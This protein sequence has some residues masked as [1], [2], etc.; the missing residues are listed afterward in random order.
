LKLKLSIKKKKDSVEEQP[1][2]KKKDRTD[3]QLDKKG[4][5]NE[6]PAEVKVEKDPSDELKYMVIEPTLT[7]SE[8]KLLH[9]LNDLL[10]E[11]MNTDVTEFESHEKTKEYLMKQIDMI[12]KKYHAKANEA[13]ISKIKYYLVRNYIGYGKIDLMMRDPNVEDISCNGPGLPIFVWHRKYESIPANILFSNPEELDGFVVK[14]AD[15]ADKAVSIAQPVVDAHLPDGSR[16]HATYEKEVTSRG[17]SFTIRKFHET[18][19]TIINL[20]ASNT[21]SARLA[22]WFWYMIENQA[23]IIAIGGTASGKTTT[24]N[25][26]A[27]FIKPNSKIVSIEDTAE[28]KLLHENWL[29]SVVRKGFGISDEKADISLFDLLKNALR[30]RPDYII[31]GEVRGVEAYTLFQA[32]A[33]GHGGIATFHAESVES[34]VR[35][36][37]NEPLNVPRQLVTNVD[38]IV[39]QG[40]VRYNDKMVRRILAV[41][42]ILLDPAT[43]EIK[44]N[45]LSKWDSHNDS[46]NVQDHSW[47]VNK[48]MRLKGVSYQ[49]IHLELAKRIMLSKIW[50]RTILQT[51]EK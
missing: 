49:E 35:R 38:A 32:I 43:K 36:F 28:I 18:P 15:T 45:I 41:S 29:P 11:E 31:V 22:A 1:A 9:E 2:I 23:S 6:Q 51:T 39:V 21:M 50:F 25:A 46:H 12:V 13:T 30:Q 8:E 10:I 27:T 42:E 3:E 20:V 37:E 33:M 40:K 48:I 24:I 7:S 4:S 19:I 47:L 34:A 44:I 5:P 14:L 17:S 26:L 16:L